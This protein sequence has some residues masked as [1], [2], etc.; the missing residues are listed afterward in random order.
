MKNCSSR[1]AGGEICFMT[2]VR[3]SRC[4]KRNTASVIPSIQRLHNIDDRKYRQRLL[5]MPPSSRQTVANIFI[6]VDV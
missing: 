4:R 5:V 3:S 6:R 1:N 2:V